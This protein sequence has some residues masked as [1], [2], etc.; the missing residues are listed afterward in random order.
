MKEIRISEGTRLKIN[1]IVNG[2]TRTAHILNFTCQC[3]KSL[4][5]RPSRL[6]PKNQ[7][8]K[9]Y[10]SRKCMG[11]NMPRGEKSRRWVGDKI[12]Y[13]GLHTWVVRVLGKPD[14]CQKCRKNG[15]SG[16]NIHWAN[17]SHEYK[18][19]IEDWLRLCTPCHKKY[20]LS[21]IGRSN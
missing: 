1:N 8:Y 7:H 20:D 15:L 16:K 9:K 18:R 3:G 17:K 21:L 5:V 11:E 13:R 19:N 4:H 2:R 6:D 14:T 12:G 10:C